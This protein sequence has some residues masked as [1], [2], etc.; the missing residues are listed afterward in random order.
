[1]RLLL[2][3]KRKHKTGESVPREQTFDI[4][5]YHRTTALQAY[6]LLAGLS[7]EKDIYVRAKDAEPDARK[8]E[9]NKGW[10]KLQL[11]VISCLW[12]SPA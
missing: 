9:K 3:N 5:R 6:K 10:F 2:L 8:T 1:L 12:K 4:E 11:E 7:L